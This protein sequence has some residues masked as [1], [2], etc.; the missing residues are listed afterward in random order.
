MGENL[1][2]DYLRVCAIFP[3]PR[4]DSES[5]SMRQI[6][7]A[8][9]GAI[10]ST[11][12]F[13]VACG[14]LYVSKLSYDLSSAKDQ[15]ELA[16][17]E[18]AV[19][20]QLR[21]SGA[22]SAGVIISIFNRADINITPLD[23]TVA[24][25][26]EIGNLYLS[27]AEQSV[28]QL[29]SSLNLSSMG[30]IASKGVGTLKARVSGVTDGKEDSFTPG[31]GLQFV[32]RLRLADEKDSIKTFSVIRRI[33]PPLATEPCLPSWTLGPRPVGCAH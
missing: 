30:T 29:K 13:I 27:S 33:L 20:I 32:V 1:A 22:S 3:E 15:R 18:P 24:H 28:D 12:A 11:V 4:I 7:T 25:S 9:Y 5:R 2:R 23:I 19:D 10:V 21:P 14:S 8:Q 16:E 6:S 17:K 31:L 26:F